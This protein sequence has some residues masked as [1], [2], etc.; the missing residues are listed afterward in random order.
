MLLITGTIRLPPT[1]LPDARP[2]MRAMIEASRAE[3]GCLDYSYA[4]DV[5]EPGLIRVNERWASRAALEAHFLSPHIAVWRASWAALDIGD[6]D[7]KSYE[8][9]PPAAT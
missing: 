2:V 3:P 1:R 8:V 4:E 6:R 7:L 5:L 9:G